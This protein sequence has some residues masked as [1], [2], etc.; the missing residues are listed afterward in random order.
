VAGERGDDTWARVRAVDAVVSDTAAI[1]LA[2]ADLERLR[3]AGPWLR[4]TGGLEWFG[5]SSKD[6]LALLPLVSHGELV[7]IIALRGSDGPLPEEKLRVARQLGD[8]LAVGLSNSRLIVRLNGL[9][10]GALS[11]L[12][13]TV[14]ANSAWTAGHSER[15]TSLSLRIGNHLGLPA[16]DMDTL[17]RGGLL[18]D[19]GKIGVP[20]HIIDLPGELSADEEAIMRAHPVTGAR[21]LSPIAA[22]ANAIP[23]VLYHHERPDGKGYP[24]GLK[25]EDIP[26]LARLLAVADVYDALV[27]DRPYRTGWAKQS[28]VEEITKGR[29]TQFDPAIVEAFLAVIGSEGDRARFSA[30][31]LEPA[32]APA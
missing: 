29:G 31:L 20:A 18:H 7:G 3:S 17:H 26:Y 27:S 9:S 1:S 2:P 14:D 13:R 6:A 8:Q 28:A 12:A 30:I 5:E 25:G 4:G 32:E 11:A 21:I 22:F 16:E 19:I 15:V 10:Y 23:I 24:E